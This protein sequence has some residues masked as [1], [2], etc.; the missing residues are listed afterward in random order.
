[1]MDKIG[2]PRGLIDYLALDDRP[3]VLPGEH[4][5]VR[6]MGT[7][8]GPDGAQDG[9]QDGTQTGVPAPT[10]A[11]RGDLDA[12]GTASVVVAGA[13]APAAMAANAPFITPHS[14]DW[15]PKPVW[16]HVLRPRTLIYTALWASIGFGLIFALF[17]RADIELTVA[18]VRNPTFVTLSDGSIRNTYDIRLRNKHGE[19]RDF[20][21]SVT[22]GGE[23][24]IALEGAEGDT[25]EVPADTTMLQRVYVV[26]DPGDAAASQQRSEFRFWVEDTGS[27]E[28]AYRDTIFNGKE[29]FDERSGNAG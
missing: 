8:A 9:V 21:L 10:A 20:K 13:A 7:D 5:P 3:P 24:D 12:D 2:R 18:P 11:A 1:V 29:S 6:P 15:T 17:I 14:R 25:V 16:K 22:D 23:L 26:A 4:A 28:R 19:A 27:G